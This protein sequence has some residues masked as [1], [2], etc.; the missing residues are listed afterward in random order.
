MKHVLQIN[1]DAKE[2]LRGLWDP[3]KTNPLENDLEIFYDDPD[4]KEQLV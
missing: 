3:A 1:P 4:F 2:V